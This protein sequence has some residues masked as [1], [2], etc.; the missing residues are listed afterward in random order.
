MNTMQHTDKDWYARYG[1]CRGAGDADGCPLCKAADDEDLAAG[2]DPLTVL[3]QAW[4]IA[5]GAAM[6][7][8]SMSRDVA[9]A[10]CREAL[11]ATLVN[12]SGLDRGAAVA[13]MM[14][15]TAG[16]SDE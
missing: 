16:S 4:I 13:L 9:E 12:D 5:V 7:E 11:V 14:L 6:G 2:M 8:E 3:R 1:F 15:A 10:E